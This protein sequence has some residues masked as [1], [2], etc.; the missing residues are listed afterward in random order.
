MMQATLAAP[1][2]HGEEAGQHD[3]RPIVALAM[4]DAA[5]VSAELAA[6]LLASEVTR[7][8]AHLVVFGDRRVLMQ[9]AR[10]AG[11]DLALDIVGSE[12]DIP[13]AGHNH[14]LVD[15]ANLDPQAIRLG[16]ASHGSGAFATENFTRALRYAAAGGAAAV[17]YLPL[18]KQAM[19][20]ANTHY[21]DDSR[22][23]CETLDWGGESREFNV[24][25]NV[26][27]ARVTSHIPLSEVARAISLDAVLKQLSF[28]DESMRLAG[29]AQPRIAVA[30][31]N[32]HAGDGGSFGREDMDILEPA[33]EA[34][35]LLGLSVD[36]PWPSDTVFLRAR[37]GLCN[38]VLT[39]YHDQGQIAM[40]L[41]GFDTG[42][43]L[44]GGLPFPVATPAHGTAYDIAGTGQ[45]S[46]AASLEA[47]K[48]VAQMAARNR[49]GAQVTL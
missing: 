46:V 13:V 25:P 49:S 7:N 47:L 44:L 10:A 34:A 4:G 22:F 35:R 16:I 15:L 11:V 8:V 3:P 18:N 9:G 21:E 17:C 37:K 19:R 43:T 29:I 38:A 33:V 36:G 40:K 48:L 27:N 32:P 28:T 24:L 5:G 45:A 23:V 39:M 41:M 2:Q 6:K 42:V 30:A 1:K 12:A 20:L 31:L 14:V 26:W